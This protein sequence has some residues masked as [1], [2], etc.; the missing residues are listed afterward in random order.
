MKLSARISGVPGLRVDRSC[1]KLIEAFEGGYRYTPS[2]GESPLQEHPYEDV[3]DCLR[4]AVM[5]K[6]GVLSRNVKKPKTYRP[7]NP[8]TGY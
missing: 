3:M 1:Q 4:Y 2:G 7:H 5:H 6:C 8:Y